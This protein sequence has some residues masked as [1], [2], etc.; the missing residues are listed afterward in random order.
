LSEMY[1]A[2]T[3]QRII[4]TA[5]ENGIHEAARRFNAP[6]STVALWARGQSKYK[7]NAEKYED[8]FRLLALHQ[9]H[10]ERNFRKVARAL[11]IPRSTLQSWVHNAEKGSVKN[12][13]ISIKNKVLS[14]FE[15]G[16]GV[17]ALSRKHNIP[18]ST[19]QGWIKLKEHPHH[20]IIASPNGPTSIGRC[21]ICGEVKQDFSNTVEGNGH[22]MTGKQRAG[23]AKR[24]RPVF[25][26][27]VEH[28][29]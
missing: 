22:W 9:Y 20:W 16:M 19:I 27:S 8:S 11:K 6:V 13:N 2:A 12:Y 28:Y 7:R 5:I 24:G 18:K 15:T 17:M 10:K 25:V 23:I 4:Q 14:D 21:K 29:E 1:T 26:P 3:K